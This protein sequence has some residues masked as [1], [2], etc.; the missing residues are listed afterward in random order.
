MTDLITPIL[1][2][3]QIAARLV[4]LDQGQVA[5]VRVNLPAMTAPPSAALN[6]ASTVAQFG[7]MIPRS[8]RPAPFSY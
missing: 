6:A 3:A 8:P 5:G 4:A 1:T 7:A 2:P